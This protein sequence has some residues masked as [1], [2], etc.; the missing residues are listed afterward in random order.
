MCLRAR[1]R[2]HALLLI[3]VKWRQLGM[4]DRI[5]YYIVSSFIVQQVPEN[6]AENGA[7]QLAAAV[8]Q[9]ALE[10]EVHRVSNTTQAVTASGES[11]G[12][13]GVGGAIH[14]ETYA[15][16]N[17]GLLEHAGRGFPVNG[18]VTA[19]GRGRLFLPAEQ[20]GAVGGVRPLPARLQGC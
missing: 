3:D 10:P 15:T 7:H 6:V 19:V 13:P 17:G 8:A 9:L 12:R 18:Q 11:A 1:V 16:F 4:P 5:R 2:I 20:F 14:Q